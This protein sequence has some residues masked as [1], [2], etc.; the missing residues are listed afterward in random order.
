[1]AEEY[2]QQVR[3]RLDQQADV[4]DLFDPSGSTPIYLTLRRSLL[5]SLPCVI[6]RRWTMLM[7]DAGTQHTSR[8]TTQSYTNLTRQL[9]PEYRPFADL[10]AA[11]L[12]FVRDA[13]LTPDDP[14]ATEQA[15]QRLENCYK[16]VP[17]PPSHLIPVD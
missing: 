14:I 8:G 3:R 4:S 12:L 15:Y 10:L 1:M 13:D 11:Y 2:L 7:D 5:V 16:W 9:F 6:H 17:R